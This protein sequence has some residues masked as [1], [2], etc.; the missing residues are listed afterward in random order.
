MNEE[1]M[2]K[3]KANFSKV[4]NEIV[5]KSK[6]IICVSI[7]LD[8]ENGE[9]YILHIF[10]NSSEFSSVSKQTK[11]MLDALELKLTDEEPKEAQVKPEDSSWIISDHQLT[12]AGTDLYSIS[13]LRYE[14][15]DQMFL[16]NQAKIATSYT[17][18]IF[19]SCGPFI[20]KTTNDDKLGTLSAAH[21]MPLEGENAYIA[22]CGHIDS[23]KSEVTYSNLDDFD[24]AI[25]DVDESA[26]NQWFR[27]AQ[28]NTISISNNWNA[29]DQVNH[30]GCATTGDAAGTIVSL[31]TSPVKFKFPSGQEI[32]FNDL[33][34]L[35]IKGEQGDSGGP[36]MDA[37]GDII[38]LIVGGEPSK[39][40]VYCSD[41]KKHENSIPNNYDKSKLFTYTPSS[42]GLSKVPGT[43]TKSAPKNSKGAEYRR[44]IELCQMEGEVIKM[45]TRIQP[46]A[47]DCEGVH[48][49]TLWDMSFEDPGNQPSEGETIYFFMVPLEL[50][51]TINQRTGLSPKGGSMAVNVYSGNRKELKS[52]GGAYPRTPCGTGTTIKAHRVT[53]D[54]IRVNGNDST[55]QR[56]NTANE[57]YNFILNDFGQLVIMRTAGWQIKPWQKVVGHPSIIN[58]CAADSCDGWFHQEILE[59]T[60]KSHDNWE[61]K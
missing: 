7:D 59:T 17:D 31:I 24:F 46:G 1:T 16:L 55:I 56:T 40:V 39:N 18:V 47:I 12:G 50:V 29:G 35:S 26:V 34:K 28:K 22:R 14:Q 27:N 60:F 23:I 57:W 44:L 54:M 21:C 13:K 43:K 3:L 61:W 19:G 4:A 41:L 38:G 42:S 6:D 30:Y 33:I 8:L 5:S 58:R 32:E 15:I 9:S 36:V 2:K 49:H 10:G 37:N 25:A 20:E 52:K 53:R 45:A 48:I 11:D 51:T